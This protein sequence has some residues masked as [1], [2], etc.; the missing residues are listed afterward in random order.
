MCDLEVQAAT[1]P[2]NY[3]DAMPKQFKF[4]SLDKSQ[5]AVLDV[6][7]PRSY[8]CPIP[9]HCKRDKAGLDMHVPKCKTRPYRTDGYEY[10]Q[11]GVR[12]QDHEGQT[13]ECVC[14]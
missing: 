12:N 5:G 3:P 1:C 6:T 9:A 2:L 7:G 8:L 10:G 4:L 14:V 13:Q 11:S